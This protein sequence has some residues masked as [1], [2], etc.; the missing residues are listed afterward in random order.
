MGFLVILG[1]WLAGFLVVPSEFLE[2]DENRPRA[3]G[4]AST[5][6]SVKSEEMDPREKLQNGPQ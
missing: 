6:P 4:G 1:V 2:A 5:R 3:E